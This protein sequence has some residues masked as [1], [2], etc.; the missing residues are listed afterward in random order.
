MVRPFPIEFQSDKFRANGGPV[1]KPWHHVYSFSKAGK[2]TSHKMSYNK[3][4]KYVVR[5][6]YLVS[7]NNNY[8]CLIKNNN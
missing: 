1:W 5:L 8:N 4:G 6:F 3:Y 2:G 7:G